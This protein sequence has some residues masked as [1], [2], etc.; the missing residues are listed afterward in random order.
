MTLGNQSLVKLPSL[1]DWLKRWT[2]V[3][4]ETVDEMAEGPE[5]SGG[6]CKLASND[7]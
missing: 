2:R 4:E 5:N 7:L 1:S 6:A 3:E